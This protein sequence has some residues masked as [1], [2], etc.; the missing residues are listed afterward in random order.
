LAYSLHNPEEEDL[1]IKIFGENI[2]KS[3]NPSL[4]VIVIKLE[5]SVIYLKIKQPG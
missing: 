1:D 5:K 2:N 4:Q 3:D